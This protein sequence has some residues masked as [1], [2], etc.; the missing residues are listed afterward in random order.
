MYSWTGIKYL[1][2]RR[3]PKPRAKIDYRRS[4]DV[5]KLKI[6][7]YSEAL[8]SLIGT[9]LKNASGHQRRNEKSSK[10][11][12]TENPKNNLLQSHHYTTAFTITID[13]NYC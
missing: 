13:I 10:P 6:T 9:V 7:R 12:P 8:C 5:Q 3:I 4:I 1:Y 11:Y 2:K